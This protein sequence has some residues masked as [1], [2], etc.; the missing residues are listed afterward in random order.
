MTRF[1]LALLL[2]APAAVWADYRP[3]DDPWVR[4]QPLIW[5]FFDFNSTPEVSVVFEVDEGGK[6]C[7]PALL[8]AQSG[9][10]VFEIANLARGQCVDDSIFSPG[11]Q[12]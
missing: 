2:L 5:R 10:E 11:A 7:G 8:F 4:H 12:R 3:E 1:L 6:I 9:D